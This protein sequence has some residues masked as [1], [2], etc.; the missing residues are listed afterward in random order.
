MV[1][2]IFLH[3]MSVVHKA[4]DARGNAVVP[5]GCVSHKHNRVN[6]ARAC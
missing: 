6:K 1:E 4:Y 5:V 2:S 3:R